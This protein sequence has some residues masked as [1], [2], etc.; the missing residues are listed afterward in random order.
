M[1]SIHILLSIFL[2]LAPLSVPARADFKYTE[3]SQITGGSVKSMV[4]VAGVFSKQAREIDKP[5]PTSRAV[6]GDRMRTDNPDGQ[7]QIIDL[8][9]RRFIT[10]DSMKH[11]YYVVTFDDMKAAMD[12]ATQN[13]QQK[14]QEDPKA[15]DANANVNVQVHVTP[16]TG[17]RDVLGQPTNEVKMEMDLQITAQQQADPSTQQ[18]AGQASG[19]MATS[20]DMFVA[21]S[22]KGYEEFGEFYKRMAKEINWVPPSN[23]HVDPRAAQSLGELERNSA[24]L[25]GFPMLKYVTMTIV[26]QG[27]DGSTAGA[28]NSSSSNSSTSNPPPSSSTSDSSASGGFPTNPGDAIA[29]GFGGL[30]NRK[31][32]Q[33][34]DAAAQNS[35]NPPPPSTPGSLIEMT[36]EVNSFS[37]D[38]LDP[39]LFEIPAGYTQ[40]QA[41][42]E[43][44][45]GAAPA[46]K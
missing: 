46:K 33:Q 14:V 10:I 6:K 13:Y 8:E 3:T 45:P 41:P 17:S 7:I 19:T 42:A 35:Q 5:I 43:P 2:L 39:S 29:K 9:G 32:K 27:A 26:V 1:K 36:E 22:V 23:I 16:G 31:K 28:P 38:S 34:D 40:V 25:Q 4:K 18:P 44:V 11:T 30:F 24:S 20:V 12:R 37:T 15:K 21:P